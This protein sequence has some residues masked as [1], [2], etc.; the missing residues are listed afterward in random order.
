VAQP[1]HILANPIMTHKA[2]W[3]PRFGEV[4][5][6]ATQHDGV[7]VDAV[8]INQAKFSE[9]VRHVRASNFDITAVMSLQRAD[10]ALKIIPNKPG[11][12]ADRLQHAQDDPFGL[13]PPRRREALVLCV[14]FRMIVVPATHD[15]IYL[16]TI[17]AARLRFRILDELAEERGT[18]RKRH[19]ID[20][21]IEGLVHC[22]NELGHTRFLSLHDAFTRL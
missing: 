16:A 14:P 22:E 9:A 3:R 12:A 6:A 7:Q 11:V 1:D 5:R 10:G 8:F 19:V 18:W 20:I 17:H 15:L 2:Q 4:W 21:A 13:V